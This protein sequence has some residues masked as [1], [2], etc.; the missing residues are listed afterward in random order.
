M[1][2]HN[3]GATPEVALCQEASRTKYTCIFLSNTAS[4]LLAAKA[5]KAYNRGMLSVKFCLKWNDFSSRKK[6]K[7]DGDDDYGF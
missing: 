4:H 6:F 3:C 1:P 2:S 7:L 5:R